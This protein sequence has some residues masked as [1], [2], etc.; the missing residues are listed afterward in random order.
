MNGEYIIGNKIKSHTH[1]SG[2]GENKRRKNKLRYI[3]GII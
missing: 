3:G 2:C 1:I